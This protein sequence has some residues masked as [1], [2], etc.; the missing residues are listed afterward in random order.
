MRTANGCRAPRP[1]AVVSIITLALA[2]LVATTTT[3]LA[4]PTATASAATT[5]NP[6]RGGFVPITPFRLVDTRERSGVAYGAPALASAETR[7]FNV[8]KAG[9]G[10]VPAGKVGSLALNVT[11]VGAGGA[12]FLAVWPSD[13]GRPTASAVNY[14]GGD[15]VANAVA[16]RVVSDGTFSVF[17][18]TSTNVVV[19]VMG[20]YAATP[21][22]TPDGGGFVGLTPNR[23]MD[24]RDALGARRFGAGGA[25]P[26]K[27]TG[28]GAAPDNAAAVVLN[29]TVTAPG[30]PGF[31]SVYPAGIGRPD[32]S[33]VNYNP[34]QTVAN[35]VTV[36][37]GQGGS[38]NL[39]SQAAADVVVDIMGWYAPGPAAPGGFVPVSPVRVLDSRIILGDLNYDPVTDSVILHLS[40]GFGGVPAGATAVSLNVTVVGPDVPSYLTVWPDGATRP[41]SSN[42]NFAIGAT[43]PNAVAVGL[44]AEGGVE[45]YTPAFPDLVADLGG[46]FTA[47]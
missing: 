39:F 37:V 17:S 6:G 38:V 14:A 42:I 18:Q 3:G 34:G 41:L 22:N 9:N 23:L 13:S 40:G 11:A 46:Y 15:I 20:Y 5:A 1:G 47:A 2:V 33:N 43:V 16:V 35:Q 12:G 32:A 7:T 8:Y 31:L 45:F 27:V 29:V 21:G 30:G 28:A 36:K 10:Q 26:L 25:A 24:T 19:D 44:G 4:G